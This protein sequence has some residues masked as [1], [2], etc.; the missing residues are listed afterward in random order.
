M[1]NKHLLLVSILAWSNIGLFYILYKL[2]INHVL[3][4]V[5]KELTLFPSFLIGIIFSAWLVVRIIIKKN[6]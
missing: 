2:E 6:K 4:G 5:F 3:V 1:K